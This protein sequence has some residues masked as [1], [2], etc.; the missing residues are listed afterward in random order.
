MHITYKQH[1]TEQEHNEC[2]TNGIRSYTGLNAS[3]L[4]ELLSIILYRELLRANRCYL[5][6]LFAV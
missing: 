2:E 4:V 5:F 3:F 6:A 1:M